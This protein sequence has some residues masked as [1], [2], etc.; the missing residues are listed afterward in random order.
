LKHVVNALLQPAFHVVVLFSD[1]Q[2][3]RSYA[4]AVNGEAPSAFVGTGL[5]PVPTLVDR[6]VV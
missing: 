5:R 4:V 3:F 1:S 2:G 6:V